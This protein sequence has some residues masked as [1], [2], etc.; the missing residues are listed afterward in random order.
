LAPT[1]NQRPYFEQQPL[2]GDPKG[3]R[4]TQV[5]LLFNFYLD[6]KH[7]L[8]KSEI[9]KISYKIEVKNFQYF[10]Q[11]VLILIQKL[12]QLEL[13]LLFSMKKRFWFRLFESV[14]TFHFS[15]SNWCW[16]LRVSHW[17]NNSCS[18]RSSLFGLQRDSSM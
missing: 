5:W 14:F 2:L 9:S 15:G 16:T 8:H 18:W 11:F 4:C 10:R 17:S 12:I 1:F 6:Q 13:W 3:G 7:V